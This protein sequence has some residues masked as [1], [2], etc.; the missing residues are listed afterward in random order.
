MQ[1]D[2][3]MNIGELN[4]IWFRDELLISSVSEKPCDREFFF[5][6]RCQSDAS[7]DLS[8]YRQTI[9]SNL[10]RERYDDKYYER[11]KNCARR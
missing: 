10:L 9:N 6:A 4:F 1:R 11:S 3:D 5:E 7:V 2:K 8:K